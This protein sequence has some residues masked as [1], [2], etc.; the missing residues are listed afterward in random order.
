[1]NKRMIQLTDITP[2]EHQ[3][4]IASV[5][6]AEIGKL[7][8]FQP[9]QQTD[10]ISRDEVRK[11]LDVDLSTVH[12]WTKKGKLK[13]YGIGNRVYFK[14]SEVEAAIKPLSE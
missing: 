6:R 7:I 3:A 12:N 9:Q 4:M 11:M 13:A 5:I 14:R 1:M 8:Q 10:F 2:E